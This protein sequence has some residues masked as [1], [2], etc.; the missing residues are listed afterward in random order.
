MKGRWCEG[1]DWISAD[2]I[3][4]ASPDLYVH[5]LCGVL[6]R[7]SFAAEGQADMKKDVV[8]R[9]EIERRLGDGLLADDQRDCIL[10]AMQLFAD[11]TKRDVD[12]ARKILAR[13]NL[14]VVEG[15]AKEKQS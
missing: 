5:L 4:E 12:A 11:D 8:L 13:P 6:A 9:A 2:D 14:R 15:A 10:D 3:L 1:L 7:F